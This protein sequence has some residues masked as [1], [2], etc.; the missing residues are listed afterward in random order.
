M[1]R[2]L[3]RLKMSVGSLPS[4]AAGLLGWL[5]QVTRKRERRSIL[6]VMSYPLA[7]EGRRGISGRDDMEAGGGIEGWESLLPLPPLAPVRGGE[8]KKQ[9]PGRLAWPPSEG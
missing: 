7:G 9:W 5:R 6:R 2:S 8:G 3:S 4:A 1:G